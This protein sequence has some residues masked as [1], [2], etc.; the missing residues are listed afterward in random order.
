MR[1]YTL[2]QLKTRI[3][4][5][6]DEENSKFIGDPELLDYI[7]ESYAD[8]WDLLVSRNEHYYVKYSN[9]N[10]VSNT[11]IY[12]LPTDFFKVMGVDYVLSSTDAIT[13]KP[14]MFNERNKD[15]LSQGVGSE[16]LRYSILGNT[17]TFSP[18]PSS[19]SQITVWYVPSAPILNDDTQVVDGVNGYEKY[20]IVDCA[21]KCLEKAETDTT[22][23]M[24]ER[25]KIIDDIKENSANRD[26]AEPYR[27]TD[28]RNERYR[29]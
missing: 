24:I 17:I 7:N 12:N 4:R 27:V 5:R 15:Y 19:T 2:A 18:S 6:A 1:A 29:R 3:R 28:V 21:I 26:V 14:F 11:Q 22:N 20:I 25:K 23:L 13:L 16:F 9:F 8:L 10:L